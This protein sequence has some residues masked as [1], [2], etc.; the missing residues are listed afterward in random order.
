MG[1]AEAFRRF[2]VWRAAPARRKPFQAWQEDRMSNHAVL[3][4]PG[5]VSLTREEFDLYQSMRT[6]MVDEDKLAEI[7]IRMR[8]RLILRLHGRGLKAKDIAK[9]TSQS[10]YAVR[11]DL[12]FALAADKRNEL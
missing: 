9:V 1:W 7:V 8:Y 5:G 3:E 11:N 6:M 4:A 10:A 12:V 2:S